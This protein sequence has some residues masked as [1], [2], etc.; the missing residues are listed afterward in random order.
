M[1]FDHLW[2]SYKFG[3]TLNPS[4]WDCNIFI[5]ICQHIKNTWNEVGKPKGIFIRTI[6][7]Y[8]RKSWGNKEQFF[9]GFVEAWQIGNA[10]S[11]LPHDSLNLSHDCLVTLLPRDAETRT[12]KKNNE[13]YP[14]FIIAVGDFLKKHSKHKDRRTTLNQNLVKLPRLDDFAIGLNAEVPPF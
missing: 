8:N 6:T 3:V 9:T 4:E 1:Q 14:T 11:N 13:I 7:K 12:N 5:S 2:I 10:W